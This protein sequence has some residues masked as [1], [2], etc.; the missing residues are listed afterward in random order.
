MIVALHYNFCEWSW[1]RCFLVFFIWFW[2]T[3]YYMTDILFLLCYLYSKDW[4]MEFFI[5]IFL[6]TQTCCGCYIFFIRKSYV[7]T[8]QRA[9]CHFWQSL[10]VHFTFLWCQV[11]CSI[12]SCHIETSWTPKL[13][14]N[15]IELGDSPSAKKSKMSLKFTTTGTSNF[16]KRWR[17]W[18]LKSF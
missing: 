2:M 7:M 8:L 5:Y 1:T 3:N 15:I 18:K 14:E 4:T 12:F 13:K 17:S 16:D 10:G 9:F 6:M 11:K